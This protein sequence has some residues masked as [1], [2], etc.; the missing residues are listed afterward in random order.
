MLMTSKEFKRKHKEINESQLKKT[1]SE[2]Y[3][4]KDQG[5][6]ITSK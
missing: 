5:G 2:D 4:K 6:E 1:F 3:I